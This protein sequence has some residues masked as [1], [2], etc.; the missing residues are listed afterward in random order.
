MGFCIDLGAGPI[1]CLECVHSLTCFYRDC[2]VFNIYLTIA[3]EMLNQLLNVD[4]VRRL[5]F[6]IIKLVQTASKQRHPNYVGP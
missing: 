4:L 6:F 5:L 2:C 3:R 1:I